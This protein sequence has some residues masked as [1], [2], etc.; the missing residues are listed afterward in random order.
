MLLLDEPVTGLDPRAQLD[1][2][3]LIANLNK[4]GITIIMVSHDVAAAV[5][6]ASHI[7]HIGSHR[8]LFF[9]TVDEYTESGVGRSFLAAEETYG[10]SVLLGREGETDE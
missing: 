10:V 8:Q 4:Q 3:E 2:Y 1:L 7:L 6:Y 9:G 5:R